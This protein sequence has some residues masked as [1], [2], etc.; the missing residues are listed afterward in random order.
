MLPRRRN[1][2]AGRVRRADC[3]HEWPLDRGHPRDQLA[4]HLH[5]S[6]PRKPAGV[7]GQQAADDSGL[8]PRAQRD[9]SLHGEVPHLLHHGGAAHH[10]VVQR[11]VQLVQLTPQGR[12][13]RRRVG[14]LRVAGHGERINPAVRAGKPTRLC[15]QHDAVAA[16][17]PQRH[18]GQRGPSNQPSAGNPGAGRPPARPFPGAVRPRLRP[19][20]AGHRRRLPDLRHAERRPHQ[21]GAGMPRTDRRPVPSR[22]PPRHRQAW[23]VGGGGRPR[24]IDRHR[25]L[26]RN[27]RQRARLLPRLHRAALGRPGYRRALGHR[28]PAR[29]H[30]RHGA[31]AEAPGGQH[32]DRAPVRRRR[33]LD[34]RHAG[35][36]MGRHLP[37]IQVFAAV[38]IA[39][40]PFHSAQNIAFHEVGRQA[41]FADPD[42]RG[43]RYWET[44]PGPRARPGGG[45]DGGAHH[46][47]FGAGAHPQVRPPP[48]GRT[49]PREGGA[50]PVRRHVRGGELPAPPGQH[51]RPPVRR[52]LLPHHHPRDGLFRPRG[53]A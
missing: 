11:S 6:A 24:T 8:A 12:K 51:L 28:L 32:G 41:I 38:P 2:A 16:P 30:P 13:V 19:D 34:G 45:A 21:R 25:P 5:Q 26:L 9:P 33:R 3:E 43:G 10:Q 49:G 7:A 20:P 14:R 48:A 31:G 50:E 40:A 27:L 42:Y 36:G 37:N 52:Q 4:P 29:H 44:G 23:L 22:A 1:V 17:W 47:P 39:T 53:R 35:A 15:G 18:T 46:L